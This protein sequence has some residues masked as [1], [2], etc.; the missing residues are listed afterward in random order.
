MSVLW[1]DLCVVSMRVIPAVILI[2][3]ALGCATPSANVGQGGV[4]RVTASDESLNSKRSRVRL[5]LASAYFGRG[6]YTTALDEVKMAIQADPNVAQ[7]YSL[8]GL[9]YAALGDVGVAQESFRRALQ[10]D[11]QDGSTMQNFGWFLCQQG[12]YPE[13]D[14]LFAQALNSPEYDGLVRTFLARGVCEARA[15][16]W[17]EAEATLK[18]AYEIEPNN[19]AVAI[20]LSQV[21]YQ[22]AEYERARFYMRRVNAVP[23]QT[24]AQSLWLAARIEMKLR[25]RQGA[26]ELG[27]QLRDRFAQSR[28]SSAFDRGSFDE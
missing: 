10:L 9:I 25:N 12:R 5:E 24:N 6:Q 3:T 22:R 27:Q 17:L 28:E 13:A 21:L 15:G 20:N 19:A 14:T 23:E 16:K 26:N 8:R 1:R 11:P 7:A 18:R 4:D 2:A